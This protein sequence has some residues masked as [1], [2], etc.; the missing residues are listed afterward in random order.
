M[1]DL[2]AHVPPNCVVIGILHLEKQSCAEGMFEVFW[3]EIPYG[4]GANE[5]A[6]QVF[7]VHTELMNFTNDPPAAPSHDISPQ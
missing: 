1:K 4:K 3:N 5:T 2:T 7:E 6:R